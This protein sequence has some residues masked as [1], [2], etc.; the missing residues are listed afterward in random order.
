MIPK[1]LKASIERQVGDARRMNREGALRALEELGVPQE[2]E[3]SE[4]YENYQITI[5]ES[6]IS[7]EQL[8]DVLEPSKQV[9]LGTRFVREVWGLPDNYICFTS[10]EGEGAYLYDRSSGKVFDFSLATRDE[11]VSGKEGPRWDGFFEFML[12]YLEGEPNL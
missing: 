2:S 1:A 10:A 5:F 4:F 3:F 9:A 11:F 7:H 12:W 8:C 6:P